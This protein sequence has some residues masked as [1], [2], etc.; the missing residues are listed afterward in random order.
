MKENRCYPLS[1]RPE[2]QLVLKTSFAH[3]SLTWHRRLGHLYFGGI[4]KLKDNDMVHGL[5][6]LD[7]YDKV[8]EGCQ[9]G[10]QHRERFP[11]GQ[12]QRAGAP[13]ELV[14][15]D[16]CGPMRIES[17]GGNKYF[18]LLVDD[19]TRMI[20]V[21]FLRFKS[22]AFTC[23]QKFKAMT[24]LQSGMKVKCVRS[25]RG[26]E[27]LSNEFKQYCDTEGIQRQ[28]SLSY[29]PYQNGVVERKNRTVIEMAKSVLHDKGMPYYMWAEAVHTVVY[30]LNRCPTKSLDSITPFE[31]Y[32][33][34][35]PG[36][37]HLKVFGSVCYVH[38][39][40]ELRHKLEPKS[41]K[42]VFV[43][44]AKCEKGYRVFD[45]IS[46]RLILSR[47]V[48]FDENSAWDWERSTERYMSLP[49]Y[50]FDTVN[51]PRSENN[52]N[53]PQVSSGSSSD[54]L[55]E[56]TSDIDDTQIN[57]QS[58][59]GVSDTQAFDHTPLKWRKLDNVLAQ[60]N[61][62]IIEPEKFEDA[63]KDES[64]MNAMKDELS[65]IEKNTTWELVDM[66]SNKPII[67]VKWVF[68]T[69]LNLDGT[70]QKN[71]ARLVAKGYAQKPGIDYNETFAHVARLDTIRTL[72]ALA[73]QK[74]W[75]LY[76]L[77]VKS[78][79]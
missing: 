59:V 34:R 19:A 17:T 40:S 18:M 26:G 39:P 79:F 31:A 48:V 25:D 78:A 50:E 58:S 65:M 70:V 69:K 22:E 2:K 63:A 1:L 21:Y 37:A 56:A 77:D 66:P 23:F 24:E 64:W 62:C 76:Q 29:T 43:G 52:E 54:I 73:A 41:I 14:H 57:S 30:L 74:S 33:K 46:K 10:K 45:P 71:K 13:L 28:L 49:T 67:G 12:A 47:D 72:I 42:G 75:K 44:Y 4:K 20:W 35:K 51:T 27:F 7:E 11:S 5:P 16:L 68:K 6:Y 15:V 3:C 55:E 36:I 32:S 38:T 8:C 60:C 61:L 9:Y 53:D